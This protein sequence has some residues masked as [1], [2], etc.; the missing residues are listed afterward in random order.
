MKPTFG[1]LA[2]ALIAAIAAG[3]AQA[4]QAAQDGAEQLILSLSSHV[5]ALN[6]PT[7]ALA[8]LRTNDL[9]QIKFTLDDS[10]LEPGD[11]RRMIKAILDRY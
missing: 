9:A 10:E 4:A 7:D 6:L 3:S 1:A 5:R 2:C 8:R 11:Q